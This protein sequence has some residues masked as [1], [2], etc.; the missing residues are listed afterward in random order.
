MRRLLWVESRPVQQWEGERQRRPGSARGLR[1][2]LAGD[3]GRLSAET[4]ARGEALGDDLCDV[5]IGIL[6]HLVE[7][8]GVVVA[9]EF[10]CRRNE[11]TGLID[12]GR[13]LF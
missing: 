8:R 6:E 1:G 13:V 9:A 3:G 4:A 11:S 12:F 5:A 10:L 7:M 2:D